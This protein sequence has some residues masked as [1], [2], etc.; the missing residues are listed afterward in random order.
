MSTLSPA[1]DPTST[2]EHALHRICDELAASFDGV[3]C[4]GLAER[5]V[6]EYCTALART[7][8]RDIRGWRGFHS[9]RTTQGRGRS[10][11]GSGRGSGF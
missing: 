4:P 10:W 7:R 2:Q 8:P 3:F 1:D 9:V 5:Y 6:L 11:T